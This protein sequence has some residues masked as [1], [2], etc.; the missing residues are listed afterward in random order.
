MLIPVLFFQNCGNVN[1]VNP[2]ITPEPV[3]NTPPVL[4][5]TPEKPAEFITLNEYQPPQNTNTIGSG[6]E[7]WI[8]EVEAASTNQNFTSTGN[9]ILKSTGE[10]CVVYDKP[11]NGQPEASFLSEWQRGNSYNTNR[12]PF[13]IQEPFE[14]RSFKVHKNDLLPLQGEDYRGRLMI[15]EVRANLLLSVTEKPCAFKNKQQIDEYE[16]TNIRF[17]QRELD[18][19]DRGLSMISEK[20]RPSLLAQVKGSSEEVCVL[21]DSE[22]YYINIRMTNV[23]NLG[24]PNFTTCNY[25]WCNYFLMY[26]F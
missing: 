6:I 17:C 11:L 15:Y 9:R 19:N 12:V 1:L 2:T 3:T 14:T 4:Q 7:V 24:N 16:K 10:G 8:N 18:D 25:K 20:S 26:M 13:V 21:P 22:Y 23:D 5:E